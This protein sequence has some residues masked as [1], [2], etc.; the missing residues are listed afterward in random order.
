MGDDVNDEPAFARAGAGSV[1][2]RIAPV[3]TPSGAQFR[4][5]A[6]SQINALLS[7]LLSL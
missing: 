4:L 3:G 7:H 2:V 5:G 6:Q 1:S